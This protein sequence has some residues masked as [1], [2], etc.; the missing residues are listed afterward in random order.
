MTAWCR[1][2]T[3]G[4]VLTELVPDAFLLK[5]PNIAVRMST[6]P[7]E[8]FKVAED[9]QTTAG[10]VILRGN[11][12]QDQPWGWDVSVQNQRLCGASKA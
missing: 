4:G 2:S 10:A 8:D 3:D 1:H 12:A 5:V 9:V 7:K 6:A 11:M